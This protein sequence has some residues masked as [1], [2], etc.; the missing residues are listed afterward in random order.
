MS[1]EIIDGHMIRVPYLER[2]LIV[3]FRRREMAHNV[4]DGNA[5]GKRNSLGHALFLAV[6]LGAFVHNGLVSKLAQIDNLGAN[7][8]DG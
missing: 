8:P 2:R 7:L 4:V 3:L 1:A 6:L 5:R